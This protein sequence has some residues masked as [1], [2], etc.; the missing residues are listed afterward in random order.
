MHDSNQAQRPID[1]F[2][3]ESG[4]GAGKKEG[5]RL[6]ELEYEKFLRLACE[7]VLD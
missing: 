1:S 3:T 7:A 4:F 2:R 6:A 5:Q